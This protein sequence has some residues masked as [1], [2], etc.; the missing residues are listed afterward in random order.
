MKHFEFRVVPF[1]Q[2]RRLKGTTPRGEDAE[3]PHIVALT[4][5]AEAFIGLDAFGAVGNTGL[6]PGEVLVNGKWTLAYRFVDVTEETAAKMIEDL[7]KEMTR[8][9]DPYFKPGLKDRG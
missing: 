4:L 6:C 5:Q 8:C 7:E 2:W 1:G 9:P 3:R